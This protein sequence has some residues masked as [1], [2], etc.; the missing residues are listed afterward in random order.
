MKNEKPSQQLMNEVYGVYWKTEKTHGPAHA[1][2]SLSKRAMADLLNL[3]PTEWV[4]DL[5]A[6]RQAL[7][8]QWSN[9]QQNIQ[10][11]VATV[12]IAEIKRRQLLKGT[13]AKIHHVRGDGA[14]LPYQDGTFSVAVSSMG[15]ELMPNQSI[16]ELARVV[17]PDGKVFLNVLDPSVSARKRDLVAEPRR[18]RRTSESDK[19][20]QEFWNYYARGE[21]VFNKGEDAIRQVM[22]EFGLGIDRIETIETHGTAWIEI[23]ATRNPIP[24]EHNVLIPG[25]PLI[26]AEAQEIAETRFARGHGDAMFG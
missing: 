21:N 8:R 4:L 9:W 2:N 17:K 13:S 11:Q 26:L 16:A 20:A 23:D 6:G 19:R 18:N 25:E 3:E 24:F 5:G 10:A 14:Q 1:R 7:E 15:L 22:G 12:D